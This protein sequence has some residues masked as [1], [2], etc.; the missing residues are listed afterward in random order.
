M[1][2]P[3]NEIGRLPLVWYNYLICRKWLTNAVRDGLD[4][5]RVNGIKTQTSQRQYFERKHQ[6]AHPGNQTSIKPM[7]PSSTHAI[8]QACL[9]HSHAHFEQQ[10]WRA[11]IIRATKK[12]QKVQWLFQIKAQNTGGRVKLQTCTYLPETERDKVPVKSV[13]LHKTWLAMAVRQRWVC[14]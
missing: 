6:E 8:V 10:L 4:V 2:Q 5:D 12:R 14:K 3:N 7:M 11:Q 9:E 1:R 13:K